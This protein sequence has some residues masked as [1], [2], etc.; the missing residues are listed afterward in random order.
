MVTSA[1]VAVLY[2]SPAE[3][4]CPVEAVTAV[5]PVEVKVSDTVDP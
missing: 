2:S 1:D 5:H 3:S 4:F